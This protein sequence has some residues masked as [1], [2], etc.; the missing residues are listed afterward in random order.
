MSNPLTRL[1]NAAITYPQVRTPRTA[2]MLVRALTGGS[3]KKTK[4]AKVY[5][6]TG[7]DVGQPGE[8]YLPQWPSDGRTDGV[9][10]AQAAAAPDYPGAL[11]ARIIDQ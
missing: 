7:L 3:S 10:A 2:A 8:R 4:N 1:R 5:R 11:N 6:G 9:V